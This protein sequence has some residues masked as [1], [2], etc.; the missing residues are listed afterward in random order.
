MKSWESFQRR[1]EKHA[2][3]LEA[4]NIAYDRS[5]TIIETGE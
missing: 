1:L 4:L 2:Q 5:D 3:I